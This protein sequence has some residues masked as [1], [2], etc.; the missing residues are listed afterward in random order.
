MNADLLK[1]LGQI[2][3]IGGFALG[4]FLILFRDII[5][6]QIFPQLTKQH[7]FSLLRL[8]VIL[9]WS[10]AVIGIAAWFWAEREK[11]YGPPKLKASLS[12]FLVSK[13][14][15]SKNLEI[16]VNNESKSKDVVSKIVYSRGPSSTEMGLITSCCMYCMGAWYAVVNGAKLGVDS[17]GT[18]LSDIAYFVSKSDEKSLYAGKVMYASGCIGLLY[19]QWEMNVSVVVLEEQVTSIR[20]EWPSKK[21]GKEE[22]RVV[23]EANKTN[24]KPD[25][26]GLVAD[27][28][29]ICVVIYFGD[30]RENKKCVKEEE[31]KERFL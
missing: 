24:S 28:D 20:I 4:V 21:D 13:N 7:A 16:I 10:F 12:T 8:I 15:E 2:A 27:I 25:V 22:K 9:V 31:I 23:N 5:R 29:Y 18:R 17:P 30:G 6:K 1:T 26:S 11:I 3:G 14:E 19:A